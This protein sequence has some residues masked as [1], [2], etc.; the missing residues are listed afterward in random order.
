MLNRTQ[1]ELKP[2]VSYV[3][4]FFYFKILELLTDVVMSYNKSEKFVAKF[5][6]FFTTF[7]LHIIVVYL[8]LIIATKPDAQ[9]GNSPKIVTEDNIKLLFEI[10]KKVFNLFLYFLNVE[11]IG[12]RL[13]EQISFCKS[14][15]YRY[16]CICC[17]HNCYI[18]PFH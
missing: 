2:S 6:I 3:V 4:S 16:H 7:S 8:Q 12:L 14:H 11:Y 15:L 5:Q 18:Q 9:Q 17:S 13:K 1:F 10:Q